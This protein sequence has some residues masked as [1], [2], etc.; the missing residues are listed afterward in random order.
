MRMSRKITLSVVGGVGAL[1]VTAGPAAA[2][3]YGPSI[4]AAIAY[5]SE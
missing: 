5:C 2:H 1:L 4:G 3:V